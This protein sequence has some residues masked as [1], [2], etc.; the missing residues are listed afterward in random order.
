MERGLIQKIVSVIE[1]K[2]LQTL[3]S[4]IT[5]KITKTISQIFK[6]LFENFGHISHGELT[7]LK[8]KVQDNVFDL[9]K[10]V[11]SIFM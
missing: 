5:G 10:P 6:Y 3:C 7:E 4:P 11:D 2:F 8:T 9:H 1:P